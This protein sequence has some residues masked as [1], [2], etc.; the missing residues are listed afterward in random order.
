MKYIISKK[1]FILSQKISFLIFNIFIGI[2][3]FTLNTY[4]LDWT[5]QTNAGQHPWKDITSSAD[6]MR[7][8]AVETDPSVGGI[9]Y[10]YTSVDY[11]VSWTRRDSAG[12]HHW[13][14]IT[15]SSD[16]M[17]LA[18]IPFED[19]GYVYTSVD[20]GVSWTRRDSAGQRAWT[21]ITSS[22]DGMRL[23]AGS[24]DNINNP[25]GYIYTSADGGATWIQ[26][27]GVGY[28]S[29]SSLSSSAD[30]MRLAAGE[31]GVGGNI[32]I[33]SDGGVTWVPSLGLESNH[34]WADIAS[35]NDGMKLATNSYGGNIYTSTD[36]GLS[37]IHRFNTGG[38]TLH[39]IA[40]S[41]DGI[42]LIAG[43]LYHNYVSI[44]SGISWII[45][46]LPVP[47]VWWN[48][49]SVS[50]DGTRFV[51]SVDGG[52]I[53][54]S[55]TAI[56]S[57]T[58]DYS[59]S[60]GGNRYITPGSTV[61]NP[62]TANLVSGTTQPINLYISSIK[63]SSNVE[64]FNQ[65]NGIGTTSS[66]LTINPVTPTQS[67]TLTL[68]ATAG[69]P[70]GVYTV[71]VNGIGDG[72]ARSTS[73]TVTV[74]SYN[75]TLEDGNT[76]NG[77]GAAGCTTGSIVL[78]WD[79]VTGIDHYKVYRQ[80]GSDPEIVVNANIAQPSSGTTVTYA[81]QD[82]ASGI[83]TYRVEGLLS[84]NTIVSS[85]QPQS[86]FAP[87]DPAKCLSCDNFT[88]PAS[89]IS[90]GSAN[91]VWNST[92]ATSCTIKNGSGTTLYSTEDGDETI[93]NITN[94][95]TYRLSCNGPEPIGED[96]MCSINR[97]LVVSVEDTFPLWL[98]GDRNDISDRIRVGREIHLNWETTGKVSGTIV[99]DTCTGKIK[100]NGSDST[101]SGWTNTNLSKDNIINPFDLTLSERG[102]YQLTVRCDRD[103]GT[104]TDSVTSNPVNIKVTQSTIQER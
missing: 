2:F 7:L 67:S 21:V 1:N 84:D 3:F 51:A 60:N 74:E 58:F 25:S 86:H 15:S 29:W 26:R 8:A 55:Y 65:V 99:P 38:I 95:Q 101:M 70:A 104:L 52:Y 40:S 78:T 28:R 24:Y 35:S 97:S 20:A 88:V 92:N 69:V 61:T 72:V 4:A 11:G 19:N 76:G 66:A 93:S 34:S 57:S 68:S 56:P 12:Q 27:T 14:S 62:I 96:N 16:G 46:D 23:A 81:D 31:W 10:I 6:G 77:G 33:S 64:V 73:F 87:V 49:F 82:L 9:G 36:G 45:Q 80:A 100:K 50:D 71:N 13:M 83:Y 98:N 43:D 102:D 75:L 39:S 37:W 41:A 53:Y 44:D 63:N 17:R 5:Q 42:K 54:T 30:G 85:S 59:L 91:L 32:Y 47:A 18:A 48:S 79:K 103:T 94:P 22:S 89:V 90:G